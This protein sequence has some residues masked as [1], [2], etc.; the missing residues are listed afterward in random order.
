M[1]GNQ[2]KPRCR[3]RGRL[4]SGRSPN[5]TQPKLYSSRGRLF[6]ALLPEGEFK[7][8]SGT[9]HHMSLFTLPLSDEGADVNMAVSNV[10]AR[11]DFGVTASTDWLKG[12]RAKVR[13]MVDVDNATELEERC[14]DWERYCD[15]QRRVV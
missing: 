12:A 5:V 3:G 14:L 1:G 7:T 8:V 11:F 2:K 9:T 15:D 13:D 10:I 4:F 6:E